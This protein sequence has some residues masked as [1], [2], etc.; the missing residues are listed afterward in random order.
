MV[1]LAAAGLKVHD[2]RAKSEALVVGTGGADK[3]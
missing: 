2:C 1:A 3:N